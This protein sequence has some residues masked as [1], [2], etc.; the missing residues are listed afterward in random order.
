MSKENKVIEEIIGDEEFSALLEETLQQPEVGS[1]ISGVVVQINESDVV[2][3]FGYK[4]EGVAQKSEFG[5]DLE[6][7][8]TVELTIVSFSGGGYVK[9]SRKELNDNT[10]WE[11]FKKLVENNEPVSVKVM[12]HVDKGYVGKIGEIQA[13]IPENHIDI[14]TK[15]IDPKTFIGKTLQAKVLRIKEGFK[16]RRSALV[17]PRQFI[18]DESDKVK[19]EFF[20]K[21]KVGDRI[22]GVVKTLKDYGAFVSLGAV[23]GFL[24]KNEIAWGRVKNPNKYLAEGDTVE[25]EVID[26]NLDDKKIAVGMRQL[27]DDPWTTATTKYKE[28]TEVQGP[29]ITRKRAGY[30]VELEN[31]IDGFIPNEELS[32]LKNARISLNAKDIV[33]GQVVG[34]DEERKRVIMSIKALSDN[35]WTTLKTDNPEGSVV[36]GTIKNIT[37]FGLFIDFG[38]L[39]DGLVRKS[40]ISW[41][42]TV[43]D[44]NTLFNVGDTIEAKVLTIDEDKERIS[45]GIKQLEANPWKE[46]T[47]LLPQGQ[48]VEAAITG[49]TKQGI[50]V[51]LPLNMVGFI[52]QNDLDPSKQALDS[53]KEGD[54]ISAMVV[55]ANAKERQVTLS[56]KKYLYDSEKRDTKEYM[57]KMAND[58]NSFSFGSIFKDKLGKV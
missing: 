9:L 39:V 24:H 58:D 29:I 54:I 12:S 15:D 47:K 4:T 57:K 45:L 23:D 28:D 46:I 5:D 53:Y 41:S 55:R 37:D 7:G 31:G 6:V 10:D 38:S 34:Y 50:Q 13:F 49:I 26:I 18:H 8:R 40:D 11:N 33:I 25:V 16:G 48:V 42:D 3:D 17:S 52:A 21:V 36:K 2:V 51:A 56:V 1:L 30:V 19:S 14:K 44:L 35:P 32:W 22:K 20:D 43:E 27:T